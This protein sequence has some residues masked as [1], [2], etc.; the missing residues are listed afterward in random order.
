MVGVPISFKDLIKKYSHLQAQVLSQLHSL[1]KTTSQANPASFLL[2]QFGMSQ[3]T[4]VGDSISNMINQVN[5][6]IMSAVRNQK[7]T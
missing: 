5:S 7:A 1:A 2:I 4:Q 3:L 6:V